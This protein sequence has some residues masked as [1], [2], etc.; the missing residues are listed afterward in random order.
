[1]NAVAGRRWVSE[2]REVENDIIY[3][4]AKYFNLPL[5][6]DIF[7]MF[8]TFIK[9]LTW[10]IKER[11]NKAVICDVLSISA[12]I[13]ALLASKLLGIKTVGIVTDMPGLMVTASL[14]KSKH[15][16]ISMG[17]IYTAV[18][19]SYLSSYSYYV[20]L[21]EQMNDV[22]NLNKRPYIVMEGLCD[23]ELSKTISRVTSKAEPKII[24]YAGG[25]HEKYGLKLLVEAFCQI[26]RDDIK[27]VV[28]GSGP[29][30]K[31]LQSIS[32]VD[33]R[34][35]Y[36]GTVS[37]EIVIRTE[38]EATL[39]INP[40][41]TNEEFTKYSFPSKNIEYMVSGTPLL[42]TKLPGM[43]KEYYPYVYLISDESVA[44]Y[45]EALENILRID[46][47]ELIEK[48]ELARNFVLQKKNNLVQTSRIVNLIN[49]H[50]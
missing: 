26:Q 6:K 50:Q 5:I 38:L 30:S 15:R 33:N 23:Y 7:V 8:H 34:V 42:T 46:S 14:D 21:T 3:E 43:P 41:P 40:R 25:L 49:Q 16:S 11:K 32:T 13:G 28:Y 19:K 2:H 36:R 35:E 24:M 44:G 10:G 29:F 31:N 12:N 22:I 4:Y 45:R 17:R 9:V 48:G 1:M 18:N 47:Q 20:F 27:L 37:N 39:L